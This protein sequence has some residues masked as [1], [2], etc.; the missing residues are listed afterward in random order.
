MLYIDFM[1][2]KGLALGHPD[3]LFRYYMKDAWF[4]DPIVK[5]IVKDID[6]ADV[7]SAYAMQHPVYGAINY[8]M[9]SSTCRTAIMLYELPNE[10]I[11]ATYCG[12]KAGDWILRIGEMQDAHIA[13]NYALLFSR[14]F[15]A[16]VV[17]GGEH[18]RTRKDYY[19]CA[20][21]YIYDNPDI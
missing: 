5:Q 14:D 4:E 7:S 15:E 3:Y 13:L 20:I 21:R 18:I 17:N 1:N 12:E 11:N 9:L 2:S 10:T 6:G 19:R 8:T 16:I